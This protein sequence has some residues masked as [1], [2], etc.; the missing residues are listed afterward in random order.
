MRKFVRIDQEIPGLSPHIRKYLRANR[1][2]MRKFV[3]IDEEIPGLSPHMRKY[4]RANQ[5]F[6]RKFVLVAAQ[7]HKQSRCSIHNLH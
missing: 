4:L 6:M 2:F 1:T 7:P 3:R 5:T